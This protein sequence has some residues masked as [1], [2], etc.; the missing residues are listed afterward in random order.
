[1]SSIPGGRY[2]IPRKRDESRQEARLRAH[3]V[4][5]RELADRVRAAA[6][7]EERQAIFATMYDELFARVPDH[8]RLAARRADSEYRELNVRWNLAQLRPYLR[9]GCTFLEVGAG[10]CALAA[11]VATEANTVY[12]VDISFSAQQSGSVPANV[13]LVVTDGRAIDVPEGSV[14]VAFSDQLMEH[15]HPEDAAAQLANIHRA[16]KPGGVYVCITPN[17]V[18]GPSDISAFFDDEA[19]GF[20]LKEYSVDEIREAFRAAGFGRMHTFIGARGAFLRVPRF[21]VRGT[22]RFVE[23]LPDGLRRKV[24][25]N[26]I[27]RALLGLRV[28]G[29]KGKT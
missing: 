19:R 7:F 14:D 1:V 12:A 3:Y 23:S 22:E 13:K 16:L 21:V 27:T 10:D 18:Y 17:R 28:A 29:I 6:S 11:R 24:A 20:H 4:V 8:P 2:F 9:P 15:L 26:K 25:D 5:E